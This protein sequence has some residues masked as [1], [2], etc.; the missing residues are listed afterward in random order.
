[1]ELIQAYELPGISQ[2]GVRIMKCLIQQA[3]LACQPLGVMEHKLALSV[4]SF[5][6]ALRCVSASV[7]LEVEFSVPRRQS[8]RGG[9]L[10]L[11]KEIYGSAVP[12]SRQP[13]KVRHLTNI[14]QHLAGGASPTITI[15]EYRHQI[16]VHFLLPTT[17]PRLV[18]LF[19]HGGP[20]VRDPLVGTGRS[21][22]A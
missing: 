18:N 16:G 4:S 21:C 10:Q 5:V 1:M 11:A 22:G 2:S 13:G 17:R 14:L 3:R 20:I 8:V 6:P 19:R 15:S 7:I 9:L 12:C